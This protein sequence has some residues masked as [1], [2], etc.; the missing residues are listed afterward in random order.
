MSGTR[1][2]MDFVETPSHLMEHFCWDVSFV[3]TALAERP[4]PDDLVQ[5]WQQS[6]HQFAGLERQNQILYAQMDQQLF[7]VPKDIAPEDLFAKLHRDYEIPYM[8]GT[9]WFTKFG[10]LV[11]YGAGYYGYLYAQMV[12]RDIWN[13][14]FLPTSST[15]TKNP[16]SRQAGTWI[17]NGLLQ[18]G[19]ARDPQQL[20]RDVLGGRPPRVD[21]S[22]AAAHHDR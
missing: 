12:A 7:G 13:T 19:G 4:L 6:R 8:P 14:C 16:A 1:A 17:W 2:A 22:L 3:Q 9:H 21:F 10:H 15:A 11:S 20:L 5:R 18:H